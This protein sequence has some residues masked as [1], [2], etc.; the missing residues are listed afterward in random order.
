MAFSLSYLVDKWLPKIRNAFSR[1]VELLRGRARPSYIAHQMEYAGVEGGVEA[2]GLEPAIFRDLVDA[3]EEAFKTTGS[4]VAESFPDVKQPDGDVAS[5]I[6]DFK[7]PGAEQFL[8]NH[9]A[10]MVTAIMDDQRQMI[11]E[12]LEA[13]LAADRNPKSVALDLVGRI[14]PATGRREGGFLGL[15]ASQARWVREYE[16]ELLTGDRNALTRRLRDP[17]FDKRFAKSIAEG[18]PLP[19]AMIDKMVIAYRNRALRY[20]AETIATT[21]AQT[22]THQAQMAATEQAIAARQLRPEAVEKEWETYRDNRVRHTHR[23]LRGV[24]VPFAQSFMS[25]SGA[26]IRFPGDPLAP[27]AERVNC[28]CYLNIRINHAA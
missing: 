7:Y 10:E 26:A 13:G 9:G 23:M 14:N 2:V 12:V 16:I 6:F 19:R 4:A 27:A 20:R 11:R 24:R 5:I 3:V 1:G 8:R 18:K 28:R 15:T 21:E 22:A 17:R 25:E